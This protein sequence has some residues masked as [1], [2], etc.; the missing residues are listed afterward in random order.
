MCNPIVTEL[1]AIMPRRKA[2]D[3]AYAI[4]C[5]TG[6]SCS[7]SLNGLHIPAHYATDLSNVTPATLYRFA[8]LLGRLGA[9]LVR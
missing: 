6:A 4:E 7:C 8:S 3:V 2:I 9:A 5:G 1:E